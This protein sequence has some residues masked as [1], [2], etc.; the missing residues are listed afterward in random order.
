MSEQEAGLTMT[1]ENEMHEQEI[2]PAPEQGVTESP[3]K[4]TRK[5]RQP[6][7]PKAVDFDAIAAQVETPAEPEPKKRTR[8]A[9]KIKGSD[10]E[11]LINHGSKLVV[12]FTGLP[13]WEIPE[14]EVSP[15]SN[16][17]ADLLNRIPG[18]YITAAA[19]FSGFLTVGIG[20]YA[21]LKPRIDATAEINRQRV[22]E[23]RARL[24]SEEFGDDGA[25]FAPSSET[26]NVPWG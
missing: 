1:D 5:P 15:W 6:R 10:V 13:F 2:T 23:R 9:A 16:E 19:S 26:D 21:T 4:R 22:A 18:Q 20:V 17:A 25:A 8:R 3:P 7:Q 24:Q 11:Q 12:M 14:K